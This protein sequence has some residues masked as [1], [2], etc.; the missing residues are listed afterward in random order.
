ME[1]LA[2]ELVWELS[3]PQPR[4]GVLRTSEE[5][6][7]AR[8]GK[9]WGWGGGTKQVLKHWGWCDRGDGGFLWVP[10]NGEECPCPSLGA[11]DRPR[12]PL[13]ASFNRADYLREV[14]KE[15]AAGI[16]KQRSFLCLC[17]SQELELVF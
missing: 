7:S 17:R 2:L 9:R 4:A 6:P 10:L 5:G 11:P 15:K 16:C 3:L 13:L 12:S 14:G 1:M 8:P